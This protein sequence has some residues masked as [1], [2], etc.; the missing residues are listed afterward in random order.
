MTSSEMKT[1]LDFKT[2]SEYMNWLMSNNGEPPP[3]EDEEDEDD[4]EDDSE[5]DDDDKEDDDD[6]DDEQLKPNTIQDDDVH[7]I[8]RPLKKQKLYR[9]YY[10]DGNKIM[11]I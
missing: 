8:D 1:L 7:K 11:E 9:M 3:D 5:D 10:V 4:N 2:Q 6:D